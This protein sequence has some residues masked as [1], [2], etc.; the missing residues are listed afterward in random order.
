MTSDCQP[1]TKNGQPA[2]STTGVASTSC[3]Q[4]DSPGSTRCRGRARCPPI[5]SSDDRHGEREADPEPPR[6]VDE[7]GIGAGVGGRRCPARAPCRRS[8]TSPDRPAGSPDASGRCRSCLPAPAPA[9]VPASDTSPGRRRTWCG[10]RP[11]RNNRACPCAR[12]GAGVCADRPSCRT[13]DRSRRRSLGDWSCED[14]ACRG[15]HGASL[16]SDTPRG[17]IRRHATG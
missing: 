12:A 14:G 6:H 5:S 9:R 4:F 17:Y 3:I 16:T 10:S 15:R 13:P 2:H 1:R 8:G 11:S 7:L